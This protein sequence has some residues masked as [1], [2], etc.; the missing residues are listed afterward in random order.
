MLCQQTYPKMALQFQ[1]ENEA[2]YHGI[3]PPLVYAET[4]EVGGESGGASVLEFDGT[5]RL[6]MPSPGGNIKL[7][8]YILLWWAKATSAK[9]VSSLHS[10]FIPSIRFGMWRRQG[11]LIQGQSAKLTYPSANVENFLAYRVLS[12]VSTVVED[13]PVVRV[14]QI[15]LAQWMSRGS[16]S[17]YANSIVWAGLRT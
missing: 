12:W 2:L 9:S 3:F 13:F 4:V 17:F 10:P 8:A 5:P 6:K 11:Q 15:S 7:P 1:A 14:Q 16:C